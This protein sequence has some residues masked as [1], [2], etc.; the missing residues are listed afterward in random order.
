MTRVSP[1]GKLVDARYS[2]LRREPWT[3]P[4]AENGFAFFYVIFGLI[5]CFWGYRLF[6][7]VLGVTGFMLGA[8]L[9][10]SLAASF[11]GGGGVLPLIAGIAGGLIGS[12]L[13]VSL[14][15]A[16]VFVLGAVAGWLV[17]VM[18][19]SLSGNTMHVLLFGLLA[20][21]GAVTAVVFQRSI[22]TVATAVLGAWYLVA[23]S[24]F[25]AGSGY[26][27][28]VMFRRPGDI[29]V[30]T[31][32]AGMVILICWSALAFSGLSF[33]FLSSRRRRKEA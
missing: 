18:L 32:G 17:G 8:Y 20:L 6:R 2:F 14:Y 25:L 10:W 31:G 13:F 27:P 28:M 23:G 5:T 7:G 24:F 16:G 15:F 4:V 21:T 29:V 19:T 33:Q 11:T 22:I 26:S 1:E 30:F 12:A 9:G 3:M